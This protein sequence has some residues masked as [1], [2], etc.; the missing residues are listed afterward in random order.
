MAKR[1]AAP[2]L[3]AA[4][5]AAGCGGGDEGEEI[6]PEEAGL[7]ST[8]P[9]N[10]DEHR[11]DPV[12]EST[13]L[14]E[15]LRA[16]LE[17]DGIECPQPLPPPKGETVTCRVRGGGETA[18]GRFTGKVVVIREGRELSYSAKLKGRGGRGREPIGTLAL[19]G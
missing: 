9:S 7:E 4:L 17:A 11:L 1:L 13:P 15:Q 18:E 14:D 2:L 8:R 10:A 3:A 16:A 6:S 12:A 5:I 19:P